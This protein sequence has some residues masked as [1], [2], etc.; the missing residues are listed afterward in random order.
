M[1]L[2]ILTYHYIGDEDAHQRGIYPVSPQ[3]LMR[4][5]DA[6]ADKKWQFISDEELSIGIS[7][8]LKLP[9]KSWL[10]TFDDALR[11]QYTMALPILA[12]RIIKSYKA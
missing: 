8:K 4:Q 6:L 11:S 9:E 1:K 5:L 2:L 3:R 12:Q 7:G 10:V